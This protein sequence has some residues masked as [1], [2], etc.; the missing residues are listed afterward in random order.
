MKLVKVPVDV[1]E[2]VNWCK[3]HGRVIDADAR[4]Q[5]VVEA[6]RERGPSSF[7]SLTT[8]I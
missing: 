8:R 2:L 1:G 5:F 7:E 6:L 4:A 3:H